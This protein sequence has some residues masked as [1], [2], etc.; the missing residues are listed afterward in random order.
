M[1]LRRGLTAAVF[2]GLVIASVA[3]SLVVHRSEQRR[4][5][6]EQAAEASRAAADLRSRFELTIGGLSTVRG[7]FAA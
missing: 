6:D 3:T 4:V 7:L 1:G 2:V 5:G